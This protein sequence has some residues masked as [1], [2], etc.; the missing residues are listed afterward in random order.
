MIFKREGAGKTLYIYTN[1]SQNEK[2][3]KKDGKIFKDLLKETVQ[4][5]GI[6]IAA[7]GYGIVEEIASN[8]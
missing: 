3:F 4:E 8:I 7:F 5:N 1:N 2:S 6:K